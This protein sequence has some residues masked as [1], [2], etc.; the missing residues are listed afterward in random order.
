LVDLVNQE[1]KQTLELRHYV[2]RLG[3]ANNS[4]IEIYRLDVFDTIDG[5]IKEPT[6]DFGT[7][8]I[9]DMDLPSSSIPRTA[10]RLETR[11]SEKL[12]EIIKG[13]VNKAIK[14]YKWLG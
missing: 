9:P 5:G 8:G 12:Q 2:A 7:E 6:V 4:E 1:L 11:E 3:G 13:A 10:D 14:S